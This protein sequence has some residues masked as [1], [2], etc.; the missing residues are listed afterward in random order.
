MLTMVPNVT[1]ESTVTMVAMATKYGSY[2]NKGNYSGIQ[3]N[4]GNHVMMSS[5]R[6]VFP[7][8][9]FERPRCF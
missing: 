2:D 6:I 8:Y 3:G 9:N 5:Q 7:P 1:L 4:F